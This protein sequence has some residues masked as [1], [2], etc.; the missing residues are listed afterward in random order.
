MGPCLTAMPP[1]API[2]PAQLRRGLPPARPCG[3]PSGGR[4]GDRNSRRWFDS[5]PWPQSLT[6]PKRHWCLG[7]SDGCPPQ[8]PHRVA[9]GPFERAGFVFF[10]ALTRAARPTRSAAHPE[11]EPALSLVWVGAPGGD[12]G[13]GP[14]GSRRRPNHFSYFLSRP[15]AKARLG[16]LVSQPEQ[17]VIG[18]A[19][20]SSKSQFGSHW[21]AALP[22]VRGHL[23]PGL[24]WPARCCHSSSSL[25]GRQET[26]LHDRFPN[27]P[28]G[29]QAGFQLLVRMLPG[30]SKA[31]GA[32]NTAAAGLDLQDRWRFLCGQTFLGQN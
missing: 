31:F 17:P 30:A 24:G 32:L 23:P 13:P 9:Q 11:R 15:F 25:Q 19:P 12:P 26:A 3:G 28:A 16:G 27:R 21:N 22:V 10:T 4:S 1:A 29:D 6:E 20:I 5:W 18:C 14:S 2:D 7:S 8:R